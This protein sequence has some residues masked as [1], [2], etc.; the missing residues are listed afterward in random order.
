MAA[1][2][3]MSGKF[4]VIAAGLAI[5]A[6]PAWAVEPKAVIQGPARIKVGQTA[7]LDATGTIQDEGQEIQWWASKAIPEGSRATVYTEAGSTLAKDTY[8]FTGNTP[9]E[10]AVN[11]AAIG[12]SEGK[13][14]FSFATFTVVV[15]TDSPAPAPQPLPDPTPAPTPTPAPNPPT[16]AP[17]PA[18]TPSPTNGWVA[19]VR[20]SMAKIDQPAD[21]KVA[22]AKA[23]A[24]WVRSVA[25]RTDL[26]TVPAFLD[27]NRTTIATGLGQNY[28]AWLPFRD[29]MKAQL[30]A[31]NQSGTVLSIEQYRQV[32]N[33][34]ADALE[35]AR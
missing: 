27:A 9:G 11:L 19:I 14:R 10:Y 5:F 2:A 24:P 17:T 31:G 8:A 12:S 25:T 34:I 26:T 22:V 3:G 18:P 7:F 35:A 30:D 15:E 21:H 16:P 20:D 13:P 33:L 1:M 4:A 29:A 23:L 32:W 28:Q 6:A